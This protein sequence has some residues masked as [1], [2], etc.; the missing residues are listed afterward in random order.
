MSGAGSR[1]GEGGVGGGGGGPG[2][3]VGWGVGGVIH[4]I[5]SHYVL[6]QVG[7]R[8]FCRHTLARPTGSALR[9]SSEGGRCRR[10]DRRDLI[11]TGVGCLD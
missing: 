3:G 11:F 1:T 5:K 6:H 4:H 10:H 8:F 9:E 7:G 2:W